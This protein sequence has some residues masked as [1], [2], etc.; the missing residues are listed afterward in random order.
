M[1]ADLIVGLRSRDQASYQQLIA[2]YGRPST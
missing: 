1:T 2:E